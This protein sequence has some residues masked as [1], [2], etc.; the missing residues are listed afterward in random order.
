MPEG[1][2]LPQA[3]IDQ[4]QQNHLSHLNPHHLRNRQLREIWARS[5][6]VPEFGANLCYG[7]AWLVYLAMLSIEKSVSYVFSIATKLVP[8]RKTIYRTTSG[9]FVRV[10]GEPVTENCTLISAF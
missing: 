2:P 9:S 3:R 6:S 4:A 8:F 1:V 7:R 5:R 10:L